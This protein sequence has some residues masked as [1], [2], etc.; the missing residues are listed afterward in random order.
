MPAADSAAA[1]SPTDTA[2][3]AVSAYTLPDGVSPVPDAGE[4][5][6]AWLTAAERTYAEQATPLLATTLS[7]VAGTDLLLSGPPGTG[8]TAL[9]RAVVRSLGL[10][11]FA[12]TLSTWTDDSSLLGPVDVAALTAGRYVRAQ[13]RWLPQAEVVFLDEVG[14]SG[15]GIRDLLLSAYA[16]RTLPDGTP[17][18]ARSIV[19]ATNTALSEEEDRAL[20]DRHVGRCT[21]REISDDSRWLDVVLGAPRPALP[22]L[23]TG[24]LPSLITAAGSVAVDRATIGASL[25]SIR[26]TLRG[27]AGL[28]AGSRAPI[29]STRRWQGAL[30]LLRAHAALHDRASLTWDDLAAVLPL[31]LADGD[32]TIPAIDLAVERAIPA[33]VAQL[34]ALRQL[35]ASLVTLARRK[36]VDGASLSADEAHALVEAEATITTTA[37][38][39]GA[40]H[41]ADVG[42]QARGIG[43]AALDALDAVADE[44][45]ARRRAARAI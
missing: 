37:T 3:A 41:G 13:G 16:E 32:E 40:E 20:A 42:R 39:I 8:K 38:A 5:A 14:R 12:S 29:V 11:L 28:P 27:G 18:C 23:P 25:A 4:A 44:A 36:H 2:A 22:A 26:A 10:T 19:G 1:V 7:I 6:R 9:V 21:L 33:W 45:H 17:I 30:S 43:L 24:V 15:R 34:A 35:T 31:A